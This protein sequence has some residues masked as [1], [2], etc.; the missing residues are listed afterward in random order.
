M[1][2]LY[3]KFYCQGKISIYGIDSVVWC[4][5][6]YDN[7]VFDFTDQRMVWVLSGTL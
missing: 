3:G 7:F 4:S 1:K 5:I 2:M 6:I